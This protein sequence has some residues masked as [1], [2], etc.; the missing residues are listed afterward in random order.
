M[1]A[2]PANF[3]HGL[4]ALLGLWAGSA[5]AGAALAAPAPPPNASPVTL[6]AMAEAERG[7]AYPTFAGI[8]PVPKDVRS[9]QAWRGAILAIEKTG[10]DMDRMAAVEPWT[11]SDT[12]GWA[13]ARRAEAIPPPPLTRAQDPG[14]DAVVAA[15]RERAKQPPRTH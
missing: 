1:K 12:E 6:G 10:R 7:A 4:A 2:R 11:L 8:P 15:M 3:L 9:F 14:L 5:A 13:A